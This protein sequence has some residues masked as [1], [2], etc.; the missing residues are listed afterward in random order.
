MKVSRFL[1]KSV[2]K[3]QTQSKLAFRIRI[4]MED[5]D[6]GGTGRKKQK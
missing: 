1:G 3:K 6:P 5:A 4:H 2:K